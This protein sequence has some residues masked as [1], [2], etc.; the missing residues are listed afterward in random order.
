[1]LVSAMIIVLVNYLFSIDRAGLFGR[2]VLLGTILGFFIGSMIYRTMVLGMLDSVRS[3]FSW[4]VL[5]DEKDKVFFEGDRQ[6][7]GFQGTIEFFNPAAAA[8]AE[9]D[10]KLNKM[11]SGVVVGV[12]SSQV[13]ADILQL[14]ICR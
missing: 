10:A 5:I 3:K 6:R 11:W 4:L 9:L 1:M 13:S 2:G 8:V 12:R 7:L 14:L